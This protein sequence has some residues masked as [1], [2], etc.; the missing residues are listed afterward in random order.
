M[1]LARTAPMPVT[2]RRRSGCASIVSNSFSPNPPFTV[3]EVDAEKVKGDRRLPFGLP[4]VNKGKKVS[5]AN[6]LWLSYFYSYP[7][8]PA[9]VAVEVNVVCH[10]A[11]PCYFQLKNLTPKGATPDRPIGRVQ[12]RCCLNKARSIRT[13]MRV[14]PNTRFGTASHQPQMSFWRLLS[15]VARSPKWRWAAGI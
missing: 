11:G 13:S 5:N 2:S 10:G 1:R 8:M 7:T 4:G 12:R 9:A 15:W 6:Y 3:D 14:Q